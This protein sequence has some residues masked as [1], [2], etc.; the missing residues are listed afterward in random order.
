M[1]DFTIGY[2]WGIHKYASALR[3]LQELSQSSVYYRMETGEK[4][5]S[6]SSSSL[7]VP[8]LCLWWSGDS[9]TVRSSWG[10]TNLDDVRTLSRMEYFCKKW[11][12][13]LEWH[14]Q[15][16]ETIGELEVVRSYLCD[17]LPLQY[18]FYRELK[19]CYVYDGRCRSNSGLFCLVVMSFSHEYAFFYRIWTHAVT[20]WPS[21]IS[22][23][24]TS[25]DIAVS[26]S[27]MFRF[28]RPSVPTSSPVSDTAKPWWCTFGSR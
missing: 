4:E 28:S 7:L 19:D 1:R 18:L 11:E 16:I 23:L 17:F 9:Y 12:L 2:F 27:L 20:R 26:S 6:Q 25:T 3:I 13:H 15:P 22:T 14:S 21:S 8:F 5:P 24:P 10:K